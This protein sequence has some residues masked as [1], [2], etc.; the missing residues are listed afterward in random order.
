MRHA[1]KHRARVSQS[2][3][4]RVIAAI[5]AIVMISG[6]GYATAAMA[7]EL[8]APRQA[9]QSTSM[10]IEKITE[11]TADAQSD[12]DAAIAMQSSAP[13]ASTEALGSPAK[14]KRIAK[15]ADGT[16]TVNVDVTGAVNSTTVVSTQPIDFTLVL[17]VSGSMREGLGGTAKINALKMAVNGFLEGA[18]RANA[19]AQPMSSPVRVG[20]VKFAGDR[21]DRIGNDIAPNGYNY[22]QVVSNLT[23][24]MVALRDVVNGFIPGGATRADFGFEHASRV[25]SGSRPDAKQVVIFFT[26]GVPTSRSSF[27]SVVANAAVSN[28]REFKDRGVTIYSIGVFNGANPASTRD[29]ANQFMHAVSSNFPNATSYTNRGQGNVNAGYYKAATNAA[30]LNAIF[31]EIRKVETT[32]S[33]YTDVVM[34]DTLSEY[35]DLSDGDYGLS[36][37]NAAGKVVS[38]IRNVDYTL[39]YD[40]DARRFAVHFLKPLGNGV[41]YTLE[42]RV[43]PTQKAY[44]D[45][46]VNRGYGETVGDAGTDLPGNDS[47][48]NMPGFRSNASA[49][50]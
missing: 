25:M 23:D 7:G 43:R 39:T 6:A 5:T 50:L 48:S 27:E 20:L 30:E 17:D 45:F 14:S 10:Q 37:R 28:A 19:E 9:D 29:E 18:A 12:D 11:S 44:D 34:E 41:T 35:V 21:T 42:Y 24:N 36:A 1:H 3:A 2:L 22:S 32:T 26:D 46:A 15:H 47:S 13:G 49:C 8:N 33:A 31:D 16:Y 38:L 40:T 4:K